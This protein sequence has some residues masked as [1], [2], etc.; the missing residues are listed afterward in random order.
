MPTLE[1]ELRRE[2]DLFQKEPVPEPVQEVAAVEARQDLLKIEQKGLEVKRDNEAELRPE[3]AAELSQHAESSDHAV[4][5]LFE[6]FVEEQ[7]EEDGEEEEAPTSTQVDVRQRSRDQ[8]EHDVRELD[9]VYSDGMDGDFQRD[10]KVV[11]GELD[12]RPE[13]ADVGGDVTDELLRK[14]RR[15]ARLQDPLALP[16][17]PVAEEPAAPETQSQSDK[18]TG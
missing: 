3:A 12:T 4:E 9:D 10:A 18:S 5:K 17:E 15:R 11:I 16:E 1:E 2:Q 7:T 13:G 6:H 8:A 14:R